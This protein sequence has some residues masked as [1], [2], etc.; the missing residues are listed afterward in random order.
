MA[1][2]R[3]PG[4]R[5]ESV[6][7]QA[8]QPL[9]CLNPDLKLI[10]VNR[11]WEELTGHPSESVL[12]LACHAHGPTRAGDLAGLGGSFYPPAEARAGRP[13]AVPTLIIHKEGERKWRRIA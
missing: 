10:W 3:V 9:F 4:V 2:T 11:A 5:L 12:G 7:Q 6:L 13:A 8:R 1:S